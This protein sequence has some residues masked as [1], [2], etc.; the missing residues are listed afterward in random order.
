MAVKAA[1]DALPAWKSN[2]QRSDILRTIAALVNENK[3]ALAEVESR[4]MGK[5]I[6]EAL[7]DMDDV[8]LTFN[9]MADLCVSLQ[10]SQYKQIHGLPD[11]RFTCRIRQEAI[12]VVAAIIPWNYPLLMAVDIYSYC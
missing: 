10:K 1:R 2:D 12:G 11:D 4:D 5:P 6:A 9:Y 3:I 7:A 8:V